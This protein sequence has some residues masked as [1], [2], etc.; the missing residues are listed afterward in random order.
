MGRREVFNTSIF[1]CI[2]LLPA[3]ELIVLSTIVKLPSLFTPTSLK[4]I[5]KGK[6]KLVEITDKDVEY[7]E[8]YGLFCAIAGSGMVGICF[9]AAAAF[10][11]AIGAIID[12]RFKKKF[13]AALLPV[14][15]YQVENSVSEFVEQ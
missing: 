14:V 6:E 11:N 4:T 13:L 5:D 12:S 7:I 1:S 9:S 3:I 15:K 8:S 2:F 10:G